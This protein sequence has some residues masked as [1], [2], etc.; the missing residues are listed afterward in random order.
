LEVRIRHVYQ[1][2]VED[3]GDFI[4]TP[5]GI[6]ILY[7]N[8]RFTIYC[9]SPRHNKL[10]QAL[11]RIPWNEFETGVK[12]RDMELRLRDLTDQMAQNGWTNADFVPHI[13]RHT[14]S[15]N[16]RYFYFL[17]RYVDD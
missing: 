2:D 16:P 10:R 1:L 9:E 3:E 14:Y 13:L 17:K 11:H 15:S 5:A 7:E 12:F 8:N 4:F 6:V